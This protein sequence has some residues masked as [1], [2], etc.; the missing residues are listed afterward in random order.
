VS[1]LCQ[2]WRLLG[3]DAQPLEKVSEWASL[4]RQQAVLVRRLGQV[5]RQRD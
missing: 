4:F 5:H 1:S 3:P 2:F